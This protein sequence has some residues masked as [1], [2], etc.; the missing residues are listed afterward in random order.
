[1]LE[2]KRKTNDHTHTN[3]SKKQ[4]TNVITKYQQYFSL[5]F[6][7]N[8]WPISDVM[9]IIFN[10]NNL[11]KNISLLNFIDLF[12]NIRFL[13]FL[14]LYLLLVV[15]VFQID[16]GHQHFMYKHGMM[17]WETSATLMNMNATHTVHSDV[18][19]LCVLIIHRYVLGILYLI[20]LSRV[21]VTVAE[22]K[23]LNVCLV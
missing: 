13:H 9:G 22:F 3:K 7:L 2:P 10:I 17:K 20:F 23:L 1:M 14:P 8:H 15:I 5:I 11:C 19:V 18:L 6:C 4:K 21:C 16:T 12:F